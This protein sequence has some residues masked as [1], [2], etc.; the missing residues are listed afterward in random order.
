[1]LRSSKLGL[2]LFRLFDVITLFV[3]NSHCPL[4]IGFVLPE[5]SNRCW[6]APLVSQTVCIHSADGDPPARGYVWYRSTVLVA[7]NMAFQGAGMEPMGSHLK[8]D[9]QK[10]VR[11]E[12]GE[13]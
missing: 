6:K 13:T 11:V 7:R 4:I 3:N 9:E 10:E 8:Q 1:V 12:V 2:V 5:Q